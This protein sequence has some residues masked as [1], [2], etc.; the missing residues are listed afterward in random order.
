MTVKVFNESP[1]NLETVV[2]IWL[3][4]NPNI[5]INRINQS[6]S[7]SGKLVLTVFYTN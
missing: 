3:S 2:N 7:D 6:Q 5:I 1:D 4:E